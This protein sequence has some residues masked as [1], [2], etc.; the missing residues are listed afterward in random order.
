MIIVE[1]YDG[2]GL[3]NQLWVYFSG[4]GIAKKLKVPFML[5]GYEKFKGQDFMH[6]HQEIGITKSDADTQRHYGSWGIFRERMFYDKNLNYFSS[7]Y[8]ERVLLIRGVT[9][10]EGLFQSEKYLFGYENYLQAFFKV[11]Q[12]LLKRNLV[13]NNLCVINLRGGEYKRHKNLILPDSYWKHAIEN[14]KHKYK[15]TEFLVVSDDKKY[16]SRMFPDFQVLDGGI[17]DCFAVL[18][19][20]KNLILSNSSFAY[21]PV[22]FGTQKNI[23]I[24]PRYW[25]RHSDILGRWASPCNLY[26][27]WLWQ[28]PNGDLHTYKACLKEALET[29]A[30]YLNFYN[31]CSEPNSFRRRFLRELIP[32]KIRVVIKKFLSFF[33][34]KHIG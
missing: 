6:L 16:A 4:V 14:M 12:K 33:F 25:A 28:S 3:G 29:E 26:S 5:L 18:F 31:V 2:Q 1:L 34:P 17:G 27:D 32:N 7:G 20:A 23:V 24:A 21:F 8:D 10:L 30:Y 11:D 19:N 9:K 15:K 13:S 22:K